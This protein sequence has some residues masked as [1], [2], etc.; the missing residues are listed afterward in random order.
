MEH[1]T[2]QEPEIF[3]DPEGELTAREV[4]LEQGVEEATTNEPPGEQAGRLR[5]VLSRRPNAFRRALRGN[6]SA[7]VEPM[8]IKL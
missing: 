7:R 4:A 1:V 2:C 6:P 8:V 5:G 3:I